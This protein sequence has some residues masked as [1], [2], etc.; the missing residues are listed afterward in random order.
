[1]KRFIFR[2]ILYTGAM[3]LGIFVAL[4]YYDYNEPSG[5]ALGGIAFAAGVAALYILLKN[6]R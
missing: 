4:K 5:L 3:V 6:Y 1:M 2:L